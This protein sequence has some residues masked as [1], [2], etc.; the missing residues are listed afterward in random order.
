MNILPPIDY[1]KNY[2]KEDI[3]ETVLIN[4]NITT[5]HNLG[6]MGNDDL[7]DKWFGIMAEELCSAS[8]GH[9]H[10]QFSQS[11]SGSAFEG[12]TYSKLPCTRDHLKHMIEGACL[13]CNQIQEL[14]INKLIRH[15]S[16]LCA[17]C[18]KKRN[19][20]TR[21]TNGEKNRVIPI[22]QDR[23]IST[24]TCIFNRHHM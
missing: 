6:N 15:L 12:M 4:Q 19:I 9:I 5:E 22:T 23:C 24:T 11:I 21:E 14:G 16:E 10:D 13:D 17:F 20:S 2:N 3:D 7:H 8:R 1:L 18:N